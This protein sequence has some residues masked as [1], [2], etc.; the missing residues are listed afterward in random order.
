[1][2][3]KLKKSAAQI[4]RLRPLCQNV[5]NRVLINFNINID[6]TDRF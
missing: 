5:L 3:L 1:M 4:E 6:R 2:E